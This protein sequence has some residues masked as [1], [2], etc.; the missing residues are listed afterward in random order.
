MESYEGSR[1]R[2]LEFASF[3]SI[4][5]RFGQSFASL[6]IQGLFGSS[7]VQIFRQSNSNS[8]FGQ[9][10]VVIFKLSIYDIYI[11]INYHSCKRT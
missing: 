4:L 7:P 1:D 8:D 9:I 5:H 3:W 10:P 6:P 11:Y 2:P